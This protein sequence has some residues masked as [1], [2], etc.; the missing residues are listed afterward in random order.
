MRIFRTEVLSL[1]MFRYYHEECIQGFFRQAL[2]LF[3]IAFP[4]GNI[5]VHQNLAICLSL[6][7]PF[8][9]HYDIAAILFDGLPFL[10]QLQQHIELFCS[11]SITNRN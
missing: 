11:T 5:C 7:A 4:I 6:V 8:R 3:Q 2:F 10:E 9:S 1:D